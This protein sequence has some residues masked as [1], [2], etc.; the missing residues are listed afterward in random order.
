MSQ[1]EYD[2]VVVTETWLHDQIYN[3]E[4]FDNYFAVYRL[5][6]CPV[7]SGHNKGEGVLI[8]VNARVST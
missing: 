8:A 3:A 2:I 6:R 4:I 1:Q 7:S 5:D